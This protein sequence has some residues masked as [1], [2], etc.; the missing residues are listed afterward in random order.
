MQDFLKQFVARL[1]YIIFIVS[2]PL[3]S[4]QFPDLVQEFNSGLVLTRPVE[5]S[6]PFDVTGKG[7][8]II[9]LE[10]WV[11]EVWV[12]PLNIVSNFKLS[13][14]LGSGPGTQRFT[15]SELAS[16]ITVRPEAT[17]FT[18][19]HEKFTVTMT[20]FA[21]VSQPAA[22][23]VLSADSRE[24]LS[25]EAT[26]SGELSL[27][28]PGVRGDVAVRFD[29][30]DS[31]FVLTDA[32]SRFFGMIGVQ[33]AAACT[34]WQKPTQKRTYGSFSFDAT[35][36]R[37]DKQD[38]VIV[39]T[40]SVRGD[41]ARV[42]NLCS[43]LRKGIESEY[44]KA[45]FH[46][47][48]YLV[49]TMQVTTP[50]RLLNDA[51]SW[52]KIRICKGF[53]EH[54]YL[55]AGLVAGFRPST[56][57]PKGRANRPGFPWY[58]GR[59]GL[60]TTFALIGSGDFSG[61]REELSFLRKYQRADGKIM[62]ELSQAVPFVNWAADYPY[63]HASAD[64][65]P[66]YCVAL[67]E[68]Y[69]ASNDKVFLKSMWQSAKN[70]YEYTEGMD[71]DSNGFIENTSG[72]HGWVE[73]GRLMPVHEETYLQ[74]VWIQASKAMARL[75][76]EMKEK[77]FSEH[78]ARKAAQSA[79]SFERILW[80]DSLSQYGFGTCRAG[81]NFATVD[82][83]VAVDSAYVKKDLTVMPAV[84][85][86]WGIPS[87]SRGTCMAGK[88][89]SAQIASDWG[90]RITGS[91]NPA[92]DPMSYHNGSVW[93]LFTGWASVACYRYGRP[94]AGYE[95]LRD[96]AQATFD[97]ALGAHP[98]L[99]SGD[100][101]KSMIRGCH[102]QVW[103]SAMVTLPFIR[104]MLGLAWDIPNSAF[105]LAPQL[106]P[107]WDSCAFRNIA[108]GAD[109]LG[110]VIKREPGVL[111]ITVVRQAGEKKLMVTC[112]PIFPADAGMITVTIDGK[113]ALFKAETLAI[114]VVCTI[115]TT[116]IGRSQIAIQYR[117]GTD[118]YA[119]FV[120]AIAG[121]KSKRLRILSVTRDKEKTVCLV[122][123]LRGSSYMF[124][125]RS[126]RPLSYMS[127]GSIISREGS[128]YQIMVD[129]PMEGGEQYATRETVLYFE[130]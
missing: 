57:D 54:P 105:T 123:G 36:P 119:P 126:E 83:N 104:G 85:M 43:D 92:Y 17:I 15:G 48:A 114:G 30:A 42:L 115:E 19:K 47:N 86:W 46:Y 21:P 89:A 27:M 97:D 26:F 125:A 3:F 98:E 75:G 41:S 34:L 37:F 69:R 130:K 22:F 68:Y 121:E 102:G 58:F 84:S 120:P 67:D 23:I 82:M 78:C 51:F 122:E 118:I 72:G 9:G 107:E 8:A 40:G 60:W 29:A 44:K 18:F 79:Q 12:Y 103:S 7:A 91:G 77:K 28:W 81:E 1:L 38:M 117:P 99:Y 62:H 109:T 2:V 116:V 94:D 6:R 13:F 65:S 50:D 14:K 49:K 16:T 5:A 128:V 108:A 63:F 20:L 124:E 55:G 71:T 73:D 66:L 70:A 35:G 113:D 39:F 24:P 80:V 61:A 4:E 10:D 95:F 53:A 90:A 93:P 96:N 52:A 88:L 31:A 129:I 59:D 111:V 112:A 100:I 110:I 45:A 33:G 76:A 101:Y 127:G 64:A 106:P 56:A 32:R 87:L 11:S 25:I 74:G